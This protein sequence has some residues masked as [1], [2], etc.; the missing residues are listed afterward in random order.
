MSEP[1]GPELFF[2]LVGPIG[3]DLDVVSSLLV[4]VLD[5]EVG[6]TS[7]TIRLVDLLREFE[8]WK[9]LPTRPL[10]EYYD[11]AMTAGDEFREQLGRADALA[12]L[13]IR[14]LRDQ[15]RGADRSPTDPRPRHAYVFRSLKQSSEVETLRR[16][17]GDSFFLI[18]TY[19]PRTQRIDFLAKRIAGSSSI[20]PTQEQRHAAEKLV[21]RDES[22]AGV[23]YGQAVRDTFPLSDLFLDVTRPREEIRTAVVRFIQLVFGHP[24]ITPTRQEFGMFHAQAAALRSSAMGRQVGA[25]LSNAEGDIQAVGTNEVP[26]AMGG[27]Y[28]GD[29]QDDRRDFQLG[30]DSNDEIKKK[31]L[32]EVVSR[33]QAARCLAPQ[34]MNTPIEDLLVE[35]APLLKGTR[36]MSPIEFGRAVHAEMSAI[37]DA[38]RRGVSTTGSLLYSTTF[39]CHECARHII[40]AGIRTVYYIEP[41]PKSLARDLHNDAVAIEGEGHGTKVSF[42]PFVGVAPRQYLNLFQMRPRKDSEGRAITW[43]GRHSLPVILGPFRSYFETE[44]WLG[45]ELKQAM[46]QT[47]LS[48]SI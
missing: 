3:T 24:F 48:L 44:D 28:W 21:D 9:A 34:L 36:I 20:S 41:Y 14:F 1:V 35:F 5:S 15:A 11:K 2:G 23:K 10:A 29:E 39:P 13:A 38:G 12:L 16:T 19:A 7:N 8:K 30:I 37:I 18:G 25:C 42:I 32:A 4:D 33:L 17:Y 26:K 40:A 45:N 47:Q 6:Y 22:E 27:Q 31:N 43:Q 46:N